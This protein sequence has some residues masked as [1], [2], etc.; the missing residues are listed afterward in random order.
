MNT[1]S[2]ST[3]PPALSQVRATGHRM[4]H[5][6]TPHPLS[7]FLPP[8]PHFH[9]LTPGVMCGLMAPGSSKVMEERASNERATHHRRA[10]A[11]SQ[12][13]GEGEGEGEGSASMRVRRRGIGRLIGMTTEQM[14]LEMKDRIQVN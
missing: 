13:E 11:C 14:R 2:C 1:G 3:K 7:P 12:H 5:H 10:A 9:A 6:I 8:I 4:P